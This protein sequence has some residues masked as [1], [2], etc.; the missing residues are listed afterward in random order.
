MTNLN[1][2][3]TSD[4]YIEQ[5][6]VCKFIS[7]DKSA[8]EAIFH[9]TKGKMKGFLKKVVPIDE[10]PENVLQEVY[11]KLWENRQ[12]INP[13][14]HFETFLF[15]IAKNLV[16]DIMRKRLNKQKYLENLYIH[17]KGG[18]NNSLDTL[19]K[20]EYSELEQKIFDL[21]EKLPKKRQLIFK[22][23]RLEGFT[24][25]EIAEQL[26]ISENT[27]D[28]QMRQALSF[29]RREMN[30]YFSILILLLINR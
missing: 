30:I 1:V 17:I 8:F 5:Q 14:N 10:D 12:S 11:V 13:N 9:H 27:V 3:K 20:I 6:L 18:Q 22:L 7:G 16:I 21:I 24:Y 4:I 28:T 25:K 29:L 26:N 23:N 15:S 2:L 19:A